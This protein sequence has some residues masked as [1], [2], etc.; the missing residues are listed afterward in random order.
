MDEYVG[1]AREHTESYHGLTTG[2]PSIPAS[3]AS[4]PAELPGTATTAAVPALELH[5]QWPELPVPSDH[6]TVSA[7][8]KSPGSAES[9]STST[10]IGE[11]P[12][13]W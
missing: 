8:A 3:D 4:G 7:M 5:V 10:P 2:S 1:I 6:A 9:G 11:G 13:A 12:A